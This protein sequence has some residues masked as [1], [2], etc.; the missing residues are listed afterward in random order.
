LAK[1]KYF[2]FQNG[3]LKIGCGL[4]FFTLGWGPA[5]AGPQQLQNHQSGLIL[6]EA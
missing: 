6:L 5:M 3:V 1:N 2:F 4:W